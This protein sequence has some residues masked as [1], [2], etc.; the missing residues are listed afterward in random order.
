M[1]VISFLFVTFIVVVLVSVFIAPTIVAYKMGKR[2]AL[3]GIVIACNILIGWSGF[4]WIVA[5]AIAVDRSS[6]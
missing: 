1:D 3:L 5:M 2:G 4:G 6:S